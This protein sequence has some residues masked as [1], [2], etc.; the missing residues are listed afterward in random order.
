MVVQGCR[1]SNILVVYLLGLH[2]PTGV[3]HDPVVE[4]Q[5]DEGTGSSNVSPLQAPLHSLRPVQFGQT[6]DVIVALGAVSLQDRDTTAAR[7]GNTAWRCW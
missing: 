5:I 6:A 7:K 2:R 3:V 4:S 1:C